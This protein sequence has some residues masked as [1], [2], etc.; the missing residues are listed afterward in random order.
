MEVALNIQPDFVGTLPATRTK[1]ERVYR[2]PRGAIIVAIPM[3]TTRFKG[4]EKIGRQM[5]PDDRHKWSVPNRDAVVAAWN[6][7]WY[8]AW[9]AMEIELTLTPEQAWQAIA[10]SGLPDLGKD[11]LGTT[12]KEDTWFWTPTERQHYFVG[13]LDSEDGTLCEKKHYMNGGQWEIGHQ[14]RIDYRTDLGL[15]DGDKAEIEN[16]NVQREPKLDDVWARTLV[17]ENFQ[18]SDLIDRTVD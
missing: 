8:D 14:H 10:A 7:G 12:A 17:R 18:D 15:S 4:V 11:P 6:R 1:P 16:P 5:R 3:S 2:K 13:M 9:H